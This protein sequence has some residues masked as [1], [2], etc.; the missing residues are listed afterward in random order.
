VQALAR[1]DGATRWRTDLGVRES[2]P[3]LIVAGEV[4]VAALSTNAFA[5]PDSA[6]GTRDLGP[7]SSVVA[8]DAAQSATRWRLHRSSPMLSDPTGDAPAGVTAFDAEASTVVG[9]DGSALVAWD[10]ATGTEQWRADMGVGAAW[11]EA[12][13]V[14]ATGLVPFDR[15]SHAARAYELATGKTQWTINT[16]RPVVSANDRP[17]NLTLVQTGD[18]PGCSN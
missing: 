12:T 4:V 18:G 15:S 3:P 8:L 9:R 14:I 11:V 16:P 5:V 1:A 2:A 10:A 17:T 13:L 7:S 6:G